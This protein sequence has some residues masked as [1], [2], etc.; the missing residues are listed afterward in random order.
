MKDISLCMIVKD[1]QTTL[2]RCLDSIK[3][4]VDEIIIVDTGSKDNTKQIAKQFTDKIY[5]FVWCDDFSKVRNF[6]LSKA[7]KQYIMWLDADDVVPKE[8]LEFLVKNKNNMTCDTYML[9]Y[10]VSF[11][12]DKPTYSFYRERILRN[13]D[14]CLWQGAVHEC[15]APFGKIA[16]INIA[17]EHRKIKPRDENRNLRI[18]NKLKRQKIFNAREQYYYSRELF[19]HQKYKLAI[20]NFNKLIKM[21]NVWLENILEAHYLLSICYNKQDNHKKEIETLFSTF[22]YDAPRANIC[23]RIASYFYQAK[24]Y[25]NAIYWFD[26]ATKCPNV[27]DKG[28]FVDNRFYNYYPY[29]G[30]C[31]AY[32]QKGDIKNA[33]YYNDKAGEYFLSKEV[34]YNKKLFEQKY[35]CSNNS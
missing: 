28:A 10:D 20:T 26:L 19:D 2:K 13:D 32:Y 25:D 22:L 11:N 12:F 15:I 30:L 4:F 5:D 35:K 23:Y 29:L 17:I 1:E 34:K 7:S 9:R 3:D 33:N 27:M 6:A 14:R 31:C 24:N 16:K 18:Y 8:T 21:K